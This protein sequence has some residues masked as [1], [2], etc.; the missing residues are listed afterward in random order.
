MPVFMQHSDA[1][2]P[3]HD[4]SVELSDPTTV[5][6]DYDLRTQKGQ[7]PAVKTSYGDHTLSAPSEERRD[8]VHTEK[9]NV[10]A[11]SGNQHWDDDSD[12]G[13]GF[14]LAGA[15][16]QAPAAEVPAAKPWTTAIAIGAGLLLVYLLT[17]KRG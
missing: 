10:V 6:F 15:P 3:T 4:P 1:P 16:D 7:G 2:T 11:R 13:D 14:Q 5:E 17:R 9:R 12:A 8:L